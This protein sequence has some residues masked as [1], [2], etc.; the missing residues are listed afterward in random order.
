MHCPACNRE[1]TEMTVEGVKLDVCDNG[2]GGIW[3]DN[4]ELKKF[5]EQHE[6]TGLLL[7]INKDDAITVDLK[8]RRKC[9]RCKDVTMMQHFFSVKRKVT[10]D[11]CQ[12]CGGVW[13]DAG[14]L[15]AIR[16]LYATEQEREQ[17]AGK[18][19][20]DVFGGQMK[21]MSSESKASAQRAHRF[22]GALRF[23]CPSNYI[24]GKQDWGAF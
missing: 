11:E 23:I 5:D 10:I 7:K 12:N 8:K 17:A 3:F 21:A 6:P 15:A 14:E 24:K 20:E 18:Y 22:A 16:D 2:C 13:L 1:L 4:F 19:F 9:P